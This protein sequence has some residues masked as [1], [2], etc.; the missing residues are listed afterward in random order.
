M[1]RVANRNIVITNLGL[2][3]LSPQETGRINPAPCT[4]RISK[5]STKYV[6]MILEEFVVD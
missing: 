3:L 2:D 6:N 5:L 1:E 4:I